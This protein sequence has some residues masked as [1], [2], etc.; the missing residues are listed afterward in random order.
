MRHFP[1]AL[2]HDESD[3]LAS[4]IRKALAERDFGFW[5]VEAPGVAAFIGFVGLGSPSFES[6]FTPCVEVGWRLAQT[7]WGR[8]YASEAASAALRHAFASL[9]LPEV[10]PSPFRPI[11]G[12]S[13]SWSALA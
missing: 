4:R 13:R 5:A 6:H 12:R 3:R 9:D 7:H 10:V 1:N 2:R 11:A 8:G